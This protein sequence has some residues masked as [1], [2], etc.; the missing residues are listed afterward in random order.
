MSLPLIRRLTMPL[1]D[2]ERYYRN[3]Q[4]I[5]A[6]THIEMGD[7]GTGRDSVPGRYSGGLQ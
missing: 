1:P 2:L 5:F 7:L 3:K 4:V 6:C